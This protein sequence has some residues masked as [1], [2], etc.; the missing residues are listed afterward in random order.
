MDIR[1]TDTARAWV[2][3]DL[4]ALVANYDD[5]T[6]RA[7][8]RVGVLPVV[9]ADAYGLGVRSVVAALEALDP[10]P[11]GYGVASVSEGAELREAGIERPVLAFFCTPEELEL[12]AGLQ[13][14]PTIGDEEGLS[15]W[16]EIAARLVRRQGQGQGQGQGRGRRLPFHL[17]I[18]TGIGRA[19][20]AYDSTERW[21]SAVLEASA[22]DLEWEGTFTHFHSGTAEGSTAE[23]WER[24]AACRAEFPAGAGGHVHASASG[25]ASRW[26]QY[27]ADLIRP[28]LFLYG[29]VDWVEGPRPSPVAT[30]RAR[31]VGVREVP[32]GWTASYGATYTAPRRSR[33]ATLAI[34]YGDG[35]RR[36]LSNAG[37]VRFG[38]RD[39]PIVGRVCM[40][41]IVVDVTDLEGVEAGDVATVIG[42]PHDG[43]T[44][45]SRVAALC[46]TIEYEILTGL[47]PRLPRRYVGA[48]SD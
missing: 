45:L 16:R 5:I 4:G 13:L 41:V 25:P 14:T 8:P 47:A 39:A 37:F 12:A 34:G 10:P 20:F 28:G 24:F 33:W 7:Q 21:L 19:G 44:S 9:K 11:W 38:Q 40:D 35:L 2:E 15:R 42:G 46:D 1:D 3:V 43:S 36:E 6:Q 27:S 17:E 29:G 22:E 23:Q 48:A 26:P 31:V 32:A 30:V 18:D